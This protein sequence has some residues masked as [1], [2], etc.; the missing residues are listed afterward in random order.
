MKHTMVDLETMGNSA[1]AAIA[2][3]GAVEFDEHLGLGRTFYKVIDLQSC[4]DI[5]LRV[6]ASTLYWWL[7]QSLEARQA[8]C[9]PKKVHVS[10]ALMDFHQ[11]LTPDTN[12]WA[13][14]VSFDIPILE[15]AYRFTAT[16]VPWKYKNLRDTRTFF[17][18]AGVKN[19][20]PTG[21]YHHALDDAK[22]QA[23]SVIIGF[24]RLRLI[25]KCPLHGDVGCACG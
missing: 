25:Y 23:L 1:G 9:E 3:I 14:G 22:N 5:G 11:W 16:S 6:D 2:S 8:L 12:L 24:Q 19:E 17:E 20:A 7:V 15:A 13:H 10:R 21:T 18:L 4:L